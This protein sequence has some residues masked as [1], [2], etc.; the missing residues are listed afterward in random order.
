[1]PQTTIAQHDP[2]NDAVPAHAEALAAW[3]ESRDDEE[4]AQ[5]VREEHSDITC[6]ELANERIMRATEHADA[7]EDDSENMVLDD[8]FERC[9]YTCPP[10]HGCRS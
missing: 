10:G 9:A 2:D 6:C 4:G 5:L 1:M 3:L 8:A 7:D